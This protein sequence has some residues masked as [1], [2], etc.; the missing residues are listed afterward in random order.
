MNSH[1]KL[2]TTQGNKPPRGRAS[3]TKREVAS[4]ELEIRQ[5]QRNYTRKL[6]MIKQIKEHRK[7]KYRDFGGRMV[8]NMSKRPSRGH[9]RENERAKEAM[10]ETFQN[11][12]KN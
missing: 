11:L 7:N 9:C 8:N 10:A 5:S 12:R 4:Q 6:K 1:P 2:Q 3:D